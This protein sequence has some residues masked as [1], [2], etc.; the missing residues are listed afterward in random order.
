MRIVRYELEKGLR[1]VFVHTSLSDERNP[2]VLKELD[3]NL[4]SKKNKEV[5][6]SRRR[7]PAGNNDSSISANNVTQLDACLPVVMPPL[8]P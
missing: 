2:D 1:G 5:T 7:F 6:S 8:G 4:Q 3:Q